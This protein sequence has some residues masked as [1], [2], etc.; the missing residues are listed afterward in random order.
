[1]TTKNQYRVIAKTHLGST[2]TLFTFTDGYLG[3]TG[4][5]KFLADLRKDP[6]P[7]TFEIITEPTT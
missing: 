5:K 4:A 1:M 3:L 2:L 7:Y 6:G